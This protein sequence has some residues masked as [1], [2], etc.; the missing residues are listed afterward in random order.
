MAGEPIANQA[1]RFEASSGKIEPTFIT[2][3]SGSVRTRFQAGDEAGV[4]HLTVSVGEFQTA[5]E[6]PLVPGSAVQ[7][8]PQQASSLEFSDTQGSILLQIPGGAVTT[9]TTLTFAALEAVEPADITGEFAG[10]HF[11]VAAF[12]AGAY[13]ETFTFAQPVGIFLTLTDE[14]VAAEE[15]HVL[16]MA[17]WDGSRWLSSQ[18]DCMSL[19]LRTEFLDAAPFVLCRAGEFALFKVPVHQLYLPTVIR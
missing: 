10:I 2:D 1:V 6:I 18:A 14:R 17:V 11:S 8:D 3:E 5:Y 12:Q 15:K 13:Q 4:A 7:V 19:G 9:E 16:K